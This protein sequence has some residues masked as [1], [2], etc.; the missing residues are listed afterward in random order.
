MER[1]I[2]KD[3]LHEKLL[4][5]GNE[6]VARGAI[7][8]G[9]QVVSGY[10]G[11]PATEIVE[12]LLNVARDN[13]IYAEWSVN[14]KVAFEVAYGAAITGL[15]SL[16]AM[17]HV[18]LNVAADA[19]MVAW[20]SGVKGGMIV[21]VADDPGA[22]ASQNEQDSRFYALQAH[23]PCFEPSTPQEAKDM[24]VRAFEISE[25]LEQLIL[26]RLTGAVSHM[27]EDVELGKVTK[28]TW[29]AEFPHKEWPRFYLDTD[30][31]ICPQHKRAH[32][33]L[34]RFRVEAEGSPFNQLEIKGHE[35]FGI[36]A[37]GAT[38]N[39]AKEAAKMLGVEN[40]IAFLKIGISHPIPTKVVERLLS[41]VDTVL[42]VEETEPFIEEQVRS[43]ALDIEHR[44]KVIGR[45]TGHVPLSDRLSVQHLANIV[46]KMVGKGQKVFAE[47][48]KLVEQ[49]LKELPARTYALC[50]GCPHMGSLFALRQVLR[51]MT[52][53][54]EFNQQGFIALA[55]IG[56]YGI[57]GYPPLEFQETEFSMGGSIGAAAGFAH[58]NIG[59]IIVASIGDS[60]FFHAGIPG[61]INAI[62]NQTKITVIVHDNSVTAMTGEQ[63]A[64]NTGRTGT[65]EAPVINI[66][67]IVR[68][69]G[70]K[71]VRVVDPYDLKTTMETI[72][73][74]INCDGVSVVVC[75]RKCAL[76]AT[77]SWARA[78]VDHQRCIGEDCGCA[79]FC[80]R[81]F[82]CPAIVWDFAAKK[83]KIDDIL[84]N[85]CGLCAQVCP[86]GAIVVEE[87]QGKWE[88]QLTS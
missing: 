78:R 39:Y 4:L 85:G 7:E 49:V 35:S 38:Y 31:I 5:L 50:S 67:D 41:V 33:V 9:V 8:A 64:P 75:K 59:E 61:L 1:Q 72:E 3:S 24:V 83:P 21:V 12:S 68:A 62:W 52:G 56:C 45:R 44:V 74:A 54:V 40:E 71:Y 6:A 87:V 28:R 2:T 76:V 58:A 46:G 82:S 88:R 69:I 26:V 60:T 15:R 77:K 57:G 18:G 42:I 13:G 43:I 20:E 17:K 81:V 63:P 11:T 51:K 80:I 34:D 27:F 19:L 23:I 73:D 48:E 66:E 29:K 14:E 25:E 70:V 53:K 79:A 55:D 47:R 86:A 10:P 65:G 32:E 37:S 36:I 30:W 84:C 22:P 16:V